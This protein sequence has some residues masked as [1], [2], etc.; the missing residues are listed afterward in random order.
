MRNQRAIRCIACCNQVWFFHL[1]CHILTWHRCSTIFPG[2]GANDNTS[3]QKDKQNGGSNIEVVPV[4]LTFREK[5]FPLYDKN[6]ITAI[7]DKTKL[8][9]KTSNCSPPAKWGAILHVRSMNSHT[10]IVE[11]NK[12]IRTFHSRISRF[13]IT[14][15]FWGRPSVSIICVMYCE[16]VSVCLLAFE[17]FVCIKNFTDSFRSNYIMTERPS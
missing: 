12:N 17:N 14:M 8:T 15:Q 5:G 11:K 4:C 1:S 3:L 2:I 6:K 9:A 13:A 10:G 7:L 16:S